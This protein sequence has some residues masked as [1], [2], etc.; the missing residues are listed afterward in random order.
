MKILSV[1]ICKDK[2][3]YV[4]M[5]KDNDNNICLTKDDKINIQKNIYSDELMLFMK[6]TFH[7][8]LKPLKNGLDKVV[9]YCDLPF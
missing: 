2:I 6:N 7:N 8:L 4:L 3:F 9:Y 1:N 5:T